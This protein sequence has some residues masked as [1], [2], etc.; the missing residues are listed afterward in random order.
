[1]ADLVDIEPNSGGGLTPPLP[2]PANSALASIRRD[3]TDDELSTPGARKLLIDRLDQ[4]EKQVAELKEFRDKYH[5]ANQQVAVLTER[6]KQTNA[7]E[8]LYGVALSAGAIFI[9]L[10]PSAW[11]SQ[12]YGVISLLTGIVLMLLA[13]LSKFIAL[14]PNIVQVPN[15]GRK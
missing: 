10:A 15:G 7:G 4:T 6:T 3:L 8:I 13:V 9:G 11:S 14:R 12:P 2:K 5:T 1:M